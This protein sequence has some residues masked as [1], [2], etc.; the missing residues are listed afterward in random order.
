MKWT[1]PSDY[2]TIPQWAAWLTKEFPNGCWI[3]APEDGKITVMEK[4]G[5]GETEWKLPIRE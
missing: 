1:K 5:N 4:R 3:G 2:G